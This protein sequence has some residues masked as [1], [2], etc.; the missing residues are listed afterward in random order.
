MFELSAESVLLMP[1][2]NM[3]E[4]SAESVSQM[5]SV[6]MFDLLT[7]SVSQSVLRNHVW[8]TNRIC[9]AKCAV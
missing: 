4:L 5:D 9:I 7:E 1:S 2:V 3:F 8:I 6:I